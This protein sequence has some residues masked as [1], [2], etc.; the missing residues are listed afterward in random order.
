MG[1]PIRLT[2][3]LAAA[4]L[5]AQGPFLPVREVRAGMKGTGRTVFEG[6]RIDEF[7]VEILGVLEN[8]GPKQTII[9]GK[10]GGA[11]LERTGVLQGMSGSPVYVGG[12]LVGAVAFA[13]PFAKEP[14]CGIRPIEEM[15]RASARQAR[16]SRAAVTPW[17]KD[18]ARLIPGSAP[19]E[20]AFGQSRL[21]EIA[22][23]VSF[24]GMTARTLEQ[25]APQLRALGLEPRRGVSGGGSA[26]PRMGD[27]RALAPGAMISVQLLS[28]DMSVAADGTVTHVD[29]KKVYAFGHRFLAIGPAELPFARSEVVALLPSLST[30]FKISAAREI[31]GTITDDR[32]TAVAGELGR[33]ARTVPLEISVA[34]RGLESA[35]ERYR[36]Q[37]VSDSF[38]TPLLVQ[39]ATFAAIDATERAVGSS[40]YVLRGELR[41]DG[42]AAPV[43]VSNMYSGD[44]NVALMASLGAASPLAFALQSGFDSLKLAGVAL[45]IESLP[46][47]RQLQIDQVWTP[48]REVRPGDRVELAISLN[49]ENGG[50]QVRRVSY[51]IPPGA[52]TGPL[53]FTVADGATTNLAEYRHL[54]SGPPRSA[55]QVLSILNGLR[56][57]TKAYVRVWRSDAGYQVQGEDLPSPPPSLALILGRG[58]AATGRGSKLGEIEID[59]AGAVITGSKT[60]QVDVKE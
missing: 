9:L 10:A 58:A 37:M 55:A 8:A 3:F 5:S 22:T 32:S 30:S 18:L 35:A 28:G 13:F 56:P 51:T 42:T 31:M 19:E 7:P 25:F 39:I 57:N 46:E 52:P 43:R 11:A 21:A 36:M 20:V 40:S 47:K 38:L 59:M 24:S 27:P 60:I 48:R 49:G 44:A 34:P 17:E 33:R 23:P 6:G 26:D 53:N 16:P 1:L 4:S 45:E 50:D 2:A 14:V 12:R 29:G 15:I 41:F 54:L